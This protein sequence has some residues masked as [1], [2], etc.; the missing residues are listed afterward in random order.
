MNTVG[1]RLIFANARK[2]IKAAGIDPAKARLTQSFLRLEQ[3]IVAGKT[4]YV[5]PILNNQTSSS[6]FN[7]EARLNMQDSFVLST[8]AVYTAIPS[9]A[10]AADFRL[11]TYPNT[12]LYSTAGAAAAT[13]TLYNGS[14]SLAVNNQILVPSWDI[15]KHLKY[16]ITQLTAAATPPVDQEDFSSDY[17]VEPNVTLRGDKNNVLTITLPG[18]GIGT[19]QANSRI[20]IILRG[21][22]A[23]NSTAVS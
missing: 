4:S 5:F 21:V 12:V 23:Q 3:A 7:T 11:L 15:L 1:A 19:I 13:T 18:T 9:G 16:P 6:I 20:V 2:S 22:L 10:T 17:P 8:L 14:L